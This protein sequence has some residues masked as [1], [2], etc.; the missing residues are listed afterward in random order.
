VIVLV[1]WERRQRIVTQH[2]EMGKIGFATPTAQSSRQCKFR[3]I[4]CVGHAEGYVDVSHI[5]VTATNTVQYDV[6]KDFF[7]SPNFCG[8]HSQ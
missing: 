2:Q 6:M 3:W 7:V 4:G 5:D 8:I 1:V